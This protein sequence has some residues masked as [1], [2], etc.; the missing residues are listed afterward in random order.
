[1]FPPG[2]IFVALPDIRLRRRRDSKADEN[3]EPTILAVQARDPTREQRFSHC[4]QFVDAGCIHLRW[5]EETSWIAE[6]ESGLYGW[7]KLA[8]I[9]PVRVAQ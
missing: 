5:D 3:I 4:A 7:Q 1:M 8:T 2:R 9:E 6:A